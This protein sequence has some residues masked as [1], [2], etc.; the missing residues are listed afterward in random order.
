MYGYIYLTTNKINNKKYIGQHKSS[1]FEGNK[2]LGSGTAL[3]RAIKKYGAQNFETKL[4]KIS[5]SKADL[6]REEKY[7]INLFNA[8]TRSDFYNIA[9]GGN[10]GE[11]H[12]PEMRQKLR[13]ARLLQESQVKGK[14]KINNGIKEKLVSPEDLKDYITKGWIKGR[15]YKTTENYIYVYKNNK[16]TAIPP[17]DLQ[18]YLD[19]GWVRGNGGSGA[20]RGTVHINNGKISKMIPKDLLNDYLSQ[21]W[22]RG[23]LLKRRAT[24][25][26]NMNSEKSAI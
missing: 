21:G 18:T 6:D 20:H 8:T 24:T 2:Y 14:I 15:L 13:Q 10:G 22:V 17:G 23:R 5:E 25:I 4:L 26:E 11:I 9:Y 1:K 3:G 7:Y 12:T 19:N 16:T